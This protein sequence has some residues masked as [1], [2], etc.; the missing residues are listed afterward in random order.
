VRQQAARQQAESSVPEVHPLDLLLFFRRFAAMA[1][2]I[3]LLKNATTGP[4]WFQLSGR[5]RETSVRTI[6][7][8][9][10]ASLLPTV[11]RIYQGERLD[12]G[13]ELGVTQLPPVVMDLPSR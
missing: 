6:V 1:C 5:T 13:L 9:R 3:R 4:R 12:A 2:A 8:W 7:R 11:F 10:M